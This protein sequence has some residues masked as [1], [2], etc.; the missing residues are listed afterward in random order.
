M[1]EVFRISYEHL[2]A[3]PRWAHRLIVANSNARTFR[4]CSLAVW[5]LDGF[6][7]FPYFSRFMS[8]HPHVLT[9]EQP[10]TFVDHF[11]RSGEHHPIIISPVDSK[12][13]AF[14]S[15]ADTAIA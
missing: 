3:H 10:P 2:L 11:R 1:P 8:P 6:I 13:A 12:R 15:H 7:V 5:S 14:G 4:I 9:V